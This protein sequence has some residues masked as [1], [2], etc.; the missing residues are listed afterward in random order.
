[1]EEPGLTLED[2]PARLQMG[3]VETTLG[4][5]HKRK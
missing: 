2:M 5:L 3:N 1:M 4:R